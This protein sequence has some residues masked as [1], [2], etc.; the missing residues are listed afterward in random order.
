MNKLKNFLEILTGNFDNSAQYNKMQEDGIEFPFAKHVNTACND[1][2]NNLPEDFKGEFMLE[3][4][5]Y[6]QK[7]HTHSSPHLF[8][9]TLESEDEVKLTSY[10]LPEGYT[11]DSFTYENLKTL[12]YADLKISEKFT[13]AIYKLKGDT[14]EGGSVSNFTPVVKFTIFER[15]SKDGLEVSESME[16][17]GKRTFGFD[18]PI[19]YKRIEK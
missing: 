5:Y 2:I 1:K 19:M 6:T 14:W 17:N 16:V 4:S 12:D 7:G 11:N 15:F 18:Y 9:F 3:E 13:P 10:E 8:L